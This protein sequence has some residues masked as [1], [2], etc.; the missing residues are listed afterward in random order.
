M[1]DPP[2]TSDAMNIEIHT[3]HMSVHNNLMNIHET[4]ILTWK[5]QEINNLTLQFSTRNFGQY[6]KKKVLIFH[7]NNIMNFVSFKE[8]IM[9]LGKDVSPS[10]TQGAKWFVPCFK[11]PYLIKVRFSVVVWNGI[12]IYHC[13]ISQ[14]SNRA[15]GEH[16]DSINRV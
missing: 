13:C 4:N 15:R 14:R 8:K 10:P 1:S 2:E 7:V 6:I 9:A 12:S 11:I 5:M 3:V 16:W